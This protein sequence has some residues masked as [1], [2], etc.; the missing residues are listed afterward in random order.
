MIWS[1][2]NERRSLPRLSGYLETRRKAASLLESYRADAQ[3][4]LRSVLHS[5]ANGSLMHTP[6]VRGHVA[7][8][9]LPL[10]VRN[11]TQRRCERRVPVHVHRLESTEQPALVQC[12]HDHKLGTF[13]VHLHHDAILRATPF[14]Q[15][16][17]QVD[18]L[19]RS[20]ALHYERARHR[21][22]MPL[23]SL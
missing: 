9:K 23:Q 21:S 2:S 20:H 11:R 8:L 16:F 3:R 19:R 15:Q 1:Y 4:V 6:H 10:K 17:S 22:R 5:H 13:D 14:E 18:C 7:S 12:L